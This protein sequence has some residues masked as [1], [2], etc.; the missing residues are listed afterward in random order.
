MNLAKFLKAPILK[1]HL[2]TAAS[3]AISIELRLTLTQVFSALPDKIDLRGFTLITG[4][5]RKTQI[6]KLLSK[7]FDGL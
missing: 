7:V 6:C 1:E 3:V 2:S 5:N 4:S